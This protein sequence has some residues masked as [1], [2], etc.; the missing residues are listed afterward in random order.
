MIKGLRFFVPTN[1]V[2]DWNIASYHDP[3]SLTWRHVSVPGV[4]S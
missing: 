3:A 2:N 1:A 4:G